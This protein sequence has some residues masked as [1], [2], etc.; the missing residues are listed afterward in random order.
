MPEALAEPCVLSGSRVGDTVL[1]PFA[2]SG[3]VGVVALK[4]GRSF[5][6]VELNPKYAALAQARIRDDAPLFNRPEV[7]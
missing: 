2:G 3:T 6:G 7:A 1:D 5:V 4:H